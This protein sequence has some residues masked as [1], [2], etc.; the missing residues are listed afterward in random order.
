MYFTI[1]NKPIT[2]GDMRNRITIVRRD[3]VDDGKGGNTITETTICQAWAA[4]DPLKGMELNNA[5]Q[6]QID[7][8]YDVTIW[9]RSDIQPEM[10]MSYNNRKFRIAAIF[11]PDQKHR[12]IKLQ[13]VEVSS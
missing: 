8:I 4:I 7:V 13:C 10:W 5:D 2:A 1:K 11:D 6:L 3:K 9:Y 12:Y